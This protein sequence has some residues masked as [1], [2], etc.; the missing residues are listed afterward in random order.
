MSQFKLNPDIVRFLSK[1]TGLAEAT[2][3]NYI[4]LLRRNYP[5]ST[6]NAVAQLYAA[7]K[8]LSVFRKLSIQDKATL[9]NIE[10]Q[11]QKTQ[12]KEKKLKQGS[13]LPSERELKQA[14]GVSDIT[15]RRTLRNLVQKGIIAREQ[16]KG[17]FVKVLD[18]GPQNKKTIRIAT[19][20]ASRFNSIIREIKNG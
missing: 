17:T 4:Y 13:K 5:T 14:Y 19:Y 7:S 11:K 6:L 8:G 20:W 16:G 10:I 12:I 9:P 15:V 2:V 1:K 18:Q 3:K